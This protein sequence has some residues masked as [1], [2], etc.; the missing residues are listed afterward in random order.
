MNFEIREMTTLDDFQA[1]INLQKIIW[2]FD[3]PYEVVPL[4][5]LM[6]SQRNDGVVL[7]AYEGKEMIGFVYALPGLH[8][9]QKVQ[10]SHMLAVKPEKQNSDIGY[11]LKMAQY[12]MSQ[13]KGY[14][15]IE[16]TYDPL[17]SRNANFNLR[18]LGCIAKEYE[19]NI[20][21]ETSSHLHR[22]S[23]TDRFI[24]HWRIPPYKKTEDWTSLPEDAVLVTKTVRSDDGL[25]RIQEVDLNRKD[26]TLFV[27]I[28]ENMQ[29]LKSKLP[30]EGLKW[31]LKTRDIFTHYFDN[32]YIAYTFLYWKQPTPFRSFYVLKKTVD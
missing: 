12:K 14:E 9:G 28:P 24:A 15:L 1:C 31:R 16:W 29:L 25:L 26:S 4:P 11:Q 10:W 18:K 5:L 13:E 8:K 22:G 23:P 27:E 2:G 7:G 20:Y 6:I 32:G 19:I 21:G 30:D 17:E 3:D